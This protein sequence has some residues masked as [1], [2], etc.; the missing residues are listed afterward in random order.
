MT[1]ASQLI[2]RLLT[3]ATWQLPSSLS[4]ITSNYVEDLVPELITD[5][6]SADRNALADAFESL[7]GS[8][9]ELLAYDLRDVLHTAISD[10]ASYDAAWGS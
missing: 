7:T 4:E 1:K 2:W 6:P 10:S 5:A 3:Q 9:L 8:E